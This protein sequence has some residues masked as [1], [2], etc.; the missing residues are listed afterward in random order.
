MKEHNFSLLLLAL[1][2]LLLAYPLAEQA[3]FTQAPTVRTLIFS[4]LL[5]IGT[6]SLKG[7]GRYY[8]VGMSFA[9]LGII[10]N[11]VAANVGSG[12]AHAGSLG[13]L[14]GFFL[15]AIIY[16]MREVLLGKAVSANRLV[17]AVCIYLLLGVLWALAYSF[18]ELASPGSYSGIP[19]SPEIGWE[20]N[21][22]Y[23][24]FVTMTTL[25]YGDILPLTPTS[26]TL[27]YIQAVTGQFYIAVLVAGLVGAYIAKRQGERS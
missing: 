15:V 3:A 8:L 17:G 16:T 27:A 1:S 21:W 10:L 22:L 11:V 23:F 24:S 14:F 19:G 5:V 6:W 20:S 2:I 26:R 9:G 12:A 7:G 25:G 4:L 13:A 18:V